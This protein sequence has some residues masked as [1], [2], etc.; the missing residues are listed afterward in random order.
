MICDRLAKMRAF[1]S[2]GFELQE[3]ED[4]MDDIE[5]ICAEIP[6]WTKPC[7]FCKEKWLK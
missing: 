4:E 5:R 1:L 2:S 3:G 6:Y 7:E